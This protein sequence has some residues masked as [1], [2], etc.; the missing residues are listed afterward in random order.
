MLGKK[1]ALIFLIIALSRSF[2]RKNPTTV[3]TTIRRMLIMGA[4]PLLHRSFSQQLNSQVLPFAALQAFK[5]TVSA[6]S[7]AALV[8]QIFVNA[9]VVTWPTVKTIPVVAHRSKA[10]P[11]S[12]SFWLL[13]QASWLSV[14]EHVQHL[15]PATARNCHILESDLFSSSLCWYH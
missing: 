6:L 4:A 7:Q 12:S 11:Q 1:T 5:N 15:S 13:L 3:Q 8:E 14:L 9:F 10:F 2:Y